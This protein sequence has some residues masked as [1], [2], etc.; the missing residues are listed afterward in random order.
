M[1]VQFLMYW[2]LELT[3]SSQSSSIM[4]GTYRMLWNHCKCNL[5]L[6]INGLDPLAAPAIQH[7]C[8][9]VVN[10]TQCPVAGSSSHYRRELCMNPE[11]IMT[12]E[13]QGCRRLMQVD[14]PH[15]TASG[16][17]R[18]GAPIDGR[19]LGR[20]QLVA[21]ALQ[22]LRSRQVQRALQDATQL[23]DSPSLGR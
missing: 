22:V 9:A 3:Q 6:L 4:L 17:F 7:I 21:R 13:K 15:W 12:N 19:R 8:P 18:K 2:I 5:L 11:C 14:T 1:A 10:R 20:Q 23:S 16:I